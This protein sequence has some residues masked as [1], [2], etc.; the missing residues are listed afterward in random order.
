M[1]FSKPSTIR[2]FNERRSKP[3]FLHRTVGHELDVHLI[4]RRV[5]VFR[6]V[7]AAESTNEW[8][9]VVVAIANFKIVVHAIVMILNLQ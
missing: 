1:V 2:T 6:D 5:D 8:R 9:V 7:V 3:G 4:R